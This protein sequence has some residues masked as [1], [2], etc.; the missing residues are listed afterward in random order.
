MRKFLLHLLLFIYIF[1]MPICIGGRVIYGSVIVSIICIIL[2]MCKRNYSREYSKLL[3]GKYHVRILLFILIVAFYSALSTIVHGTGD[4]SYIRLCI[5]MV[6]NFEV[7]VMVYGL[8]IA[9]KKDA[10]VIDYVID[11]FI[12]QAIIQ[13]TSYISPAFKSIT[14][15]FRSPTQLEYS[16]LYE[17]YRGL[18]LA[19]SGFFGLA[20]VYGFVFVLIA[21]HWK[22]WKVKNMIIR[23]M[24]L[25][26][27]MIGSISA[28]RSALFG[29]LFAFFYV[30]GKRVIEMSHRV[31]IK[32]RTLKTFAILLGGVVIGLSAYFRLAKAS[33]Q[34]LREF[35]YYF[36]TFIEGLYNGK[37][38]LSSTSGQ[39]LFSSFE[40]KLTLEQFLFG[41]GRYAGTNG[42]VNYMHQDSGYMRN[43]LLFGIF[44]LLFLF[45]VQYSIWKP[46]IKGKKDKKWMFAII[47][48]LMAMVFHIKGE[49]VGISIEYQSVSIL[50][51][52]A[53]ID[54]KRRNHMEMSIDNTG[55]NI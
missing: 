13:V 45:C 11:V 24:W 10:E 39:G 28:G 16:K 50:I 15:I 53:L 33:N 4:F 9:Y 48:C 40:Y 3:L 29:L 35:Y 44:G 46:F 22:E 36:S 26:L 20:V 38:L 19:G 27:L 8:V 2:L 5:H 52:Y 21:Y 23:L 54:E 49:V 55:N 41:D 30:M 1:D 6:F 42:A 12:I 37:G 32:K 51:C 7:G 25:C 34:S 43:L 17:G 18:G 14:D 47:I 31:V